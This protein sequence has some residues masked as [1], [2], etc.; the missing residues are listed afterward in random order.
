MHFSS[1]SITNAV[2]KCPGLKNR[3]LIMPFFFWQKSTT[4]FS[5]TITI[6]NK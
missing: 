5:A 1:S 4:I 3:F 2:A 6:V